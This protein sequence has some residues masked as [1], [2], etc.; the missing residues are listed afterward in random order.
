LRSLKNKF[1]LVISI[2]DIVPIVASLLT[3]T[4][5]IF[6][7]CAKSSYYSYSYTPWEKYLL[8]KYCS[9]CFPRDKKTTDNLIKHGIK[10]KYV[11]N[12]M[13]D[14]FTITGD[15]F[16]IEED[17][18]VVGILPGTRDDAYLNM[19]DISL[20]AQELV[21]T[22]KNN[23]KKIEFLVAAAPNKDKFGDILNVSDV[24]IGL[25]GTGN[26]QA[27]GLGRPV[28]SFPGRGVQYTASFAKRQKELLGE[29]LYVIKNNPA[30]VAKEVWSLLHDK[31]RRQ[32]MS[33]AGKERMGLPGAS[34]EIANIIKNENWL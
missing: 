6:I 34:L 3:K 11:G 16:G 28:I 32:K 15:N 18:F 20:A 27:A 8:K 7:G 9:L 24:I 31:N 10:A 13:M 23:N 5:F 21:K 25:S 22:A 17:V 26:E 2:G 1:D 14:C 30:L 29:A 19:E 12:P 33:Q 4:R